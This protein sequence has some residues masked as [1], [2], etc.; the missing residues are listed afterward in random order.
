MMSSR[1]SKGARALS[2]GLTSVRM[3]GDG[4]GWSSGALMALSVLTAGTAG[5][6]YKQCFPEES[7]VAECAKALW[8][9]DLY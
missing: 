9:Y 2:R 7:S 4:E 5:L 6:L 3:R 1:I 8:I